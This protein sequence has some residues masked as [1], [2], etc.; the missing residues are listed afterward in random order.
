MLIS[1]EETSNHQLE[2]DLESVEN[3]LVLSHY[4]LL[5][6]TW[7]KTDRCAGA[8]SWGRNQLTVLHISGRFLLTACLRRRMMSR[9]IYLFIYS[10]YTTSMTRIS[11]NSRNIL[12]LLSLG[13]LTVEQ[14]LLLT[15][16]SYFFQDRKRIIILEGVIP[17]CG[18]IIYLL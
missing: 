11:A 17:L 8:L 1:V 10:Y 3:A 15:L 5:E 9:Y 2:P 16:H 7:P 14:L 12:K 6:N 4:S 13:Q 18:K